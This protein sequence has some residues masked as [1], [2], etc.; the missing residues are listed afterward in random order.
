MLSWFYTPSFRL[1]E[2]ESQKNRQCTFTV[3]FPKASYLNSCQVALHGLTNKNEVFHL[4]KCIVLNVKLAP[5]GVDVTMILGD[6]ALEVSKMS[7]QKLP[8]SESAEIIKNSPRSNKW[9]MAR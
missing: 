9:L 8:I 3:A 6:D 1:Y 2:G 4:K 5:G 7:S